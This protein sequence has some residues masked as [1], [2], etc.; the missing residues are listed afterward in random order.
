MTLAILC[1]GQGPQGPRTFALT[2]N[3]PRAAGLFSHATHLL[4]ADPR[5]LARSADEAILHRNRTGQILCVLQALAATAALREAWPDR[6][7]VAGYSVGEMAAWSVAGLI[8]A[9]TTLDLVAQRADAMDAA[10]R[11][12][13]GLLF[14]RGLSRAAI[15][16][17]CARHDAA[18]AIVNP[19]DA[20]VLGG[21]RLDALAEEARRSGAARVVRLAVGVASHTPRL[22]AATAAF[23][24]L[25]GQ[26]PVAA[27][28]AADARLLSGIDGSA[29][30]DI[31]SGLDKLAAQISQTVQWEACLE[32]CI[33][34]GAT[35]FLELGPGRALAEM[36]AG[37]HHGIA[38][39]SLEDFTTLQGV[40]AWLARRT[41]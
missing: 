13:D 9:A 16:A 22:T 39:R 35:A 27:R 14:V 7:I 33:E 6:L 12:G 8:D 37:A 38:A 10:S 4:G 2:G 40:D 1:S 21:D 41:D 11:A 3:A 28:P 36:A 23:R 5:A 15:D 29:V 17:L 20:Y 31:R 19:G 34:A 25:L 24:T 26:V 32:S 18:V 30:L